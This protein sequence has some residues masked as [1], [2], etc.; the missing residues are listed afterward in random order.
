MVGDRLANRRRYRRILRLGLLPFVAIVTGAP[1]STV[2]LSAGL[3]VM[4]SLRRYEG[5]AGPVPTIGPSRILFD[6]DEHR[7]QI[8]RLGHISR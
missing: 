5:N 8:R 2:A 6:D 3:A 1:I 7:D 4:M